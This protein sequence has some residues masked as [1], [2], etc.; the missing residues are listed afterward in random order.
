MEIVDVIVIGAGIAGL[1]AA[2]ELVKQGKKV[3]ILE[4]RE[5][6]GGRIHTLYGEKED[7]SVV[8][9]KRFKQSNIPVN[10][11]V[12]GLLVEET[13]D[14]SID[15]GEE[16]FFDLCESLELSLVQVILSD[17]ILYPSDN[18]RIPSA[19]VKRT[20]NSIIDRAK[21]LNCKD[22][23]YKVK[24]FNEEKTVT[25]KEASIFDVIQS[26]TESEETTSHLKFLP[27]YWRSLESRLGSS[28][29]ETSY[30]DWRENYSET[31]LFFFFFFFVLFYLF[32]LKMENII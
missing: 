20:F 24:K 21:E 3:V 2:N 25:L 1:S 23:E 29:S 10:I 6:L 22:T 30:L 13:E 28:L 32:Y 15:N 19:T 8:S 16:T 26:L 17:V 4:A 12:G 27:W 14:K 18:D 7:L 9:D 11:D 5:R 31:G